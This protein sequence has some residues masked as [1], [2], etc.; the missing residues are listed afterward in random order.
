VVTLG[1][2]P[3][4]AWARARVTGDSNLARAVLAAVAIIA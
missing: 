3:E 2:T 1:L 4:H